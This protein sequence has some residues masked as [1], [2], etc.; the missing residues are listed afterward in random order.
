MQLCLWEAAVCYHKSASNVVQP[1]CSSALQN[2]I[3][4]VTV[5]SYSSVLQLTA[6]GSE[7]LSLCKAHTD[8]QSIRLVTH[9]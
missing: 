4:I 3:A 5:L 8:C 9:T 1:W 2:M 6:K 7:H